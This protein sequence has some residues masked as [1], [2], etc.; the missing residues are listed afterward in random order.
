MSSWLAAALAS[1]AVLAWPTRR[2]A[3]VRARR[4]AP[5]PSLRRWRRSPAAPGS[6]LL[7]VLDAVTAQLR[8]GAAPE[9][10]WDAA[11]DL[12]DPSAALRR[13]PGW[14]VPD[15]LS[16]PGPAVAT[17]VAA[18]WRLAEEVGA[19]LAEVL[20][21]LAAGLR[22]D[23]ELAT[24]VEASLAAPRATA[25]LLAVLP[26]GGIAL[27]EAIGAGPLSVLLTTG[28]GRLSGAAGLA[29]AAAGHV[30][31][32]RLVARAARVSAAVP[33]GRGT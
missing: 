31:T 1:G 21:R 16:R 9:T 15:T 23:V 33:R 3:A 27:G 29:L 20:E 32:R 25:R 17:G 5:M 30:W 11:V 28:A 2:V 19:P 8:G 10:A 14:S 7:P 18:A 22:E 26:V 24:E 13:P 6:A 12:L 4:V